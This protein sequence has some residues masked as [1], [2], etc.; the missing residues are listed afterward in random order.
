MSQNDSLM[1]K[2]KQEFTPSLVS[3]GVAIAGATM[4]LN[5]DLSAKYPLF[6]YNLPSYVAIGGVVGGS[7]LASELVHD[8]VLEKLPDSVKGSWINYENRILSPV[9]AG[10]GTYL[11][12]KFGVSN[13]TDA[14]NSI[15]LGSGSAVV[16]KY[17][18]DTFVSKYM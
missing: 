6:G 14:V 18:S 8:W 1:D 13:D 11:L 5:V 7:V 12:F 10:A 17:V 2:L 16:G 9:L 4:L 15:L 3:A